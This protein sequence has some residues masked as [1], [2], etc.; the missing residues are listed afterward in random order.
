MNSF[1][2][3]KCVFLKENPVFD[4]S[5][6]IFFK[7]NKNFIV[8]HAENVWCEIRGISEVVHLFVVIHFLGLPI[9]GSDVAKAYIGV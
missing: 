9:L 1:F 8:G 2:Y 7:I 3:L 5:I 4:F 6:A